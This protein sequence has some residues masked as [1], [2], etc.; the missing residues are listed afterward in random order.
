[1]HGMLHF[2]CLAWWFRER[3]LLQG[4]T[5]VGRRPR[6]GLHGNPL[7]RRL[8]RWLCRAAEIE[9]GA[10]SEVVQIACEAGD[11]WAALRHEPVSGWVLRHASLL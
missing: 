10:D 3:R 4:R 2:K 9:G 5:R 7:E 8:L 11:V 1:M 6:Q